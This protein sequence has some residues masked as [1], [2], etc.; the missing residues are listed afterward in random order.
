MDPTVALRRMRSL[1]NAYKTEAE[2]PLSPAHMERLAVLGEDMLD[3]FEYL[4]S[5]LSKGGFL[6]ADWQQVDRL[7]FCDRCDDT[8]SSRGPHIL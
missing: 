5:W 4:D 7:E 6:P 8:H 3:T 1:I 2:T